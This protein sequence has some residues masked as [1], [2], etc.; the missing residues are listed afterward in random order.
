MSYDIV[1]SQGGDIQVS[2]EAGKGSIFTIQLP[3]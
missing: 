2:S 3:A 1:K